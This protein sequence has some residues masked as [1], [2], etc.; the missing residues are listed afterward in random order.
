[1]NTR[2]KCVNSKCSRFGIEEPYTA[3]L[4][5]GFGAGKDRV[6][7]LKCGEL[8]QITAEVNTSERRHVRPVTPRR[9]TPRGHGR[10]QTGR[11]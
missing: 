11:S 7:C 5:A 8:L 9:K 2:G 10:G 1:M 6:R 3:P 4:L